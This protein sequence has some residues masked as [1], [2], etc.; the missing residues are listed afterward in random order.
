M[1][2][3]LAAQS[4]KTLTGAGELY[5]FSNSLFKKINVKN[6]FDLLLSA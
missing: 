1:E 4:I 3:I 5:T 2:L 6:L